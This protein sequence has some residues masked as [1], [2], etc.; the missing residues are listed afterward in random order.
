MALQDGAEVAEAYRQRCFEEPLGLDDAD[1]AAEE[2]VA[3]QGLQEKADF[4]L[5]GVG[6]EG[7]ECASH[8]RSPNVTGQQPGYDAMGLQQA[9]SQTLHGRFMTRLSAA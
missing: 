9:S 2:V 4:F 3:Q 7:L 1:L 6:S 5:Q 8:G